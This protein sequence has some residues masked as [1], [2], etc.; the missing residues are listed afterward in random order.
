MKVAIVTG[1]NKGIG[2]GIVKG[3][4][5]KFNGTV[6]LTARNVGRGEAAVAELKKLGLKPKFH[7]LDITDQNSLDTFYDYMKKEY[8]GIDV[9]VNNA[10]IAYKVTATEPFGEQAKNTLHVNYFSL[11]NACHTLF[12]LL[13]PHARVVNLSSSAGH[14]ARIPGQKLKKKLSSPTLT[15]DQLSD[16]MKQ[17]IESA[18]EGKH[19]QDGWPNSAYSVSKVAVSALTF[20]QQ[21]A[22]DADPREDLV[23]N[24]VHPGY[25]DTDMTSHKGPL[26]IEEGADA[27]VYLALLPINVKSPR[28]CYVWSNRD[29][30]DWVKGP[31]PGPY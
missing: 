23:V 6:Y 12:P 2:Y 15:E 4:C 31:T 9:L 28:G 1:G 29:I 13:N 16:L 21:H 19:Q 8:G 7:Q 14:L 17:F 11:L 27:A 3:L 25:V 10:A 5:E 26:T 30:V 22:F 18:T 24:A 20:I